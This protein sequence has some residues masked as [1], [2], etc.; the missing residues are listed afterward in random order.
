MSVRPATV[1]SL[2]MIFARYSALPQV[3][4]TS[5]T[6]NCGLFT[7]VINAQVSSMSSPMS[8]SKITGIAPALAVG[9]QANRYARRD[10]RRHEQQAFDTH[11]TVPPQVVKPMVLRKT[12]AVGRRTRVRS[13]AVSRPAKTVPENPCTNV[14][15]SR[16]GCPVNGRE[17]RLCP[18]KPSCHPERSEAISPIS[19]RFF[20]PLR[21]TPH[22]AGDITA[23]RR[24][25]DRAGP[26]GEPVL[27]GQLLFFLRAGILRLLGFVSPLQAGRSL[28]LVQPRLD[29][30]CR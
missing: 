26:A 20:A 27:G 22:V 5:L 23:K 13:R 11:E 14:N 28:D 3:V 29:W 2:A 16:R 4:V 6:S 18:E 10:D 24:R 25:S 1:S 21:M 17:P 15:L 9:C 19:R 7:S 30:I 8:V 12:A